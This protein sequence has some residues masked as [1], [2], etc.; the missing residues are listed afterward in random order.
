MKN[1]S[2]NQVV[3]L[4]GGRGSRLIPFTNKIPKPMIDINGKPF[5][6]IL[7][8]Y[9][10]SLN[11]NNILLLT[12][13]KN[14]K[15]LDYFGDGSKFKLNIEYSYST[16]STN[17]AKR[18]FLAKKKLDTNF[19]LMYSDNFFNFDF[20]SF[21]KLY[22]KKISLLITKKK[23]GNIYY[24]N[25]LKA[26]RYNSKRNIDYTYIDLGCMIINKDFV[27]KYLD[28][29]NISF[30]KIIEKISLNNSISVKEIMNSYYSIGDIKRLH[31]TKQFLKFKKIILIDRDGV[32]NKKAKKGYYVSKWDQMIFIKDTIQTLM[33]LSNKG[34][35]FIIISNQA[36]LS[37]NMIN[38]N[39]YKEI[40]YNLAKMFKIKK[41]NLLNIYTCPHHWDEKCLCR[42]PNPGLFFKA[43][44]RYNFRLDK[45]I[46]IG[47]QQTD[48]EASYNAF[49]KPVLLTN[50]KN[51][52]KIPNKI[53]PVMHSS[54]LS[55]LIEKIDKIYAQ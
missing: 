44:K 50:K 35:K 34:Y 12:G 10:K 19:L 54:K 14:K 53:K 4:C 28:N 37:R 33:L 16:L 29:K 11:F 13:Y 27:F 47:D 2:I 43:S 5:L 41:I 15:I 3:I 23:P 55:T 48:L 32:I 39:D 21:C 46:Y 24:D 36:G 20:S 49:V 25:I 40:N 8:E 51:F 18:I 17:T 9:L 7:I 38:K 31:K 22:K 6:L 1:K 30:N 42:K 45:V 52:N 26:F